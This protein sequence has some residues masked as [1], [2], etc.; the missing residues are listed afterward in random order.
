MKKFSIAAGSFLCL[1]LVLGLVVAGENVKSGPQIGEELAGPFHPLNLTGNSAGEKHCL[2]C[3][4]GNNPVAM[5]FAR[6]LN[7]SVTSLIKKID[8]STVEHADAKMGSFVVFLKDD[9]ELQKK[10][11]EMAEK[12]KIKKTVLSVDNPAGPNGYKVSK[13]AEVTVV[14]YTAHTVKANY[15]FGKGE[16][17]DKGIEKVLGDV[18][19]ILPKSN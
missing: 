4:N 18:S 11:K 14:L 10:A 3:E 8:T 9:E 7:D 5:I 16:L 12:E 17:D 19:K 6:D 1:A 13:D 2:Y 15:A